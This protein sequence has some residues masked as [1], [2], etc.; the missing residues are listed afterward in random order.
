MS[1]LVNVCFYERGDSCPLTFYMFLSSK[2]V[3]FVCAS[4]AK[5]FSYVAVKSLS[6]I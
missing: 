6:T 5:R 4:V 2:F 3:N 1:G